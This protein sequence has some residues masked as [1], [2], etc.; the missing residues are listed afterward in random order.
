M[1]YGT[2]TRLEPQEVLRLGERFFGPEGLGLEVRTRQPDCLELA[3]PAGSVSLR[4]QI[5]DGAT[6][7]FLSTEGMDEQVRRFMVEVYEE[8]RP[9]SM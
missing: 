5:T 7:A 8:A 1:N 4:V 6:E 9:H 2:S 3:G